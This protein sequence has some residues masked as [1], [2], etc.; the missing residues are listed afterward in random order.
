MSLL[1]EL[2]PL[3]DPPTH[4]RLRRSRFGWVAVAI[5]DATAIALVLPLVETITTRDTPQEGLSGR[6]M[7]LVGATDPGTFAVWL[8]IVVLLGFVTKSVLA[9]VM[10]RWNLGLVY[11]LEMRTAER[12]TRGYLGAPWSFHL[13]RNTSS[14]QRT[15]N[16]GLRRV[17]E[18]GLATE[19]PA[20]GDRVVLALIGLV[21]LVLAPLPAIAV[22]LYL[23]VATAWYLDFS[24]SAA[25]SSSTDLMRRHEE[26]I[27][28]IQQS[29]SSVREIAVTGTNEHFVKAVCEVREH[30]AV[31]Q[32]QLSLWENL[33]RY[34]LEL[35]MLIAVALVAVVAFATM[36]RHAAVGTIGLFTAAGFRGLPSLNRVLVARSKAT[37]AT[38]HLRQMLDDLQETAGAPSHGVSDTSPLEPGRRVHGIRFDRVSYAYPDSDDLALDEVSLE[39]GQGRFV[40]VVGAS[41]AG[42]STLIGLMLGLLDPTSGA[43]LVDDQPLRAR[44]RSYQDQLGY[45]PQEVAILHGSIRE[46]VAFGI[47]PALVDDD[48]V[49][50]ALERAELDALVRSLPHGL[51]SSAGEGGKQMSGGQRQRLGLARALFRDPQVLV[52]DEATSALD[53][54]TEQKIL[55]TLRSLGQQMT[56]VSVAHRPSAVR[57]CDEVHLLQGGRLI[58]SG[59]FAELARSSEDFRRLMAIDDPS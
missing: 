15:L 9:I 28:F 37:I 16:D 2:A 49:W 59:P 58:A 45:V 57:G 44:R 40:G 24:R 21:L 30:I 31:R 10:L 1:R 22:G 34:L 3:I 5:L 20:L 47:D 18:E 19:L 4:R 41:G 52:L 36:P 56:V 7:G 38:P 27:Q 26:S 23:A 46:N 54:E 29:L 35:G 42:K 39:L 14:V 17:F 11:E 6:L 13:R 48:E 50:R 51:E 25:R 43:L 32:R 55:A 33:P 8:A 53:T 12:L